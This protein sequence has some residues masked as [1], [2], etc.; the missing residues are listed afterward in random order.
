MSV[1]AKKI[2]GKQRKWL[3]DYETHTSFEPMYQEQLDDGS[4][5]FSEVAKA[6][7]KWFEDWSSGVIGLISDYPG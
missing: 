2:N 7:I 6:N 1:Y 4:M 3:L 5:I